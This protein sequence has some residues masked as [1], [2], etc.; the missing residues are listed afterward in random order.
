MVLVPNV[1]A[2]ADAI[3]GYKP[4]KKG[5][6]LRGGSWSKQMDPE[7]GGRQSELELGSHLGWT[8]RRNL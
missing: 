3:P 5:N 2:M 7:W 6:V 1:V 8:W 4:R